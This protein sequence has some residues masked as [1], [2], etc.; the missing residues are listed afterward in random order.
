MDW[1]QSKTHKTIMSYCFRAR[2][3]NTW[4][5]ER[6]ILF[7]TQGNE[8][9]YTFAYRITTV[10]LQCNILS[11]QSVSL[12]QACACY[13]GHKSR[14]LHNTVPHHIHK[15]QKPKSSMCF[16]GKRKKPKNF[17]VPLP[18][19][20]SGFTSLHKFEIIKSS[21]L[22]FSR[23]HTKTFQIKCFLLH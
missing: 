10:D 21:D 22:F 20:S 14:T 9:K 11:G 6:I 23:T 15:A 2:K 17:K 5:P 7:I 3:E 18:Q 12:D 13:F 16:K 1:R 19:C 4:I 8:N